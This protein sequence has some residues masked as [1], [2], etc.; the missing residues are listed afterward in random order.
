MKNMN[1]EIRPGTLADAVA[2]AAV[3]SA[4]WEA[5]YSDFVPQ[6]YIAQKRTR[7]VAQMEQMLTDESLR[8]CQYVILR[9]GAIVGS[10]TVA[11]A[12][13]ADLDKE[14]FYE[15][16]GIYLHPSCFRYGIGTQAV[17][18]AC[19][20]AHRLNKTSMSLWVFEDNVSSIRFYQKCGFAPD[21]KS[22]ILNCGKKLTAIRMVKDISS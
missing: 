21:G 10:M 4:S 2:M 8:D 18:F 16:W 13:D 6:D 5:A 22:K 15:I 19:A 11:L 9:D 1:I 17:A 20:L 12:R 7:S 14:T 3:Y